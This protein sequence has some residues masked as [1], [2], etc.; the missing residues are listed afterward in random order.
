LPAVLRRDGSVRAHRALLTPERKLLF[1]CER[2]R[3]LFLSGAFF[4]VTFFTFYLN[5]ADN[6]PWFIALGGWLAWAAL[7]AIYF[8]YL[9]RMGKQGGYYTEMHQRIIREQRSY[10]RSAHAATPVRLVRDQQ[11]F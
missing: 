6:V 3:F 11:R 10:P 9:R 7:C 5:V 2:S 8:Y 1:E 4:L